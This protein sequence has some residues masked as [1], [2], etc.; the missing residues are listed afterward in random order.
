MN[1]G[2]LVRLAAAN[3]A[4]CTAER[5]LGWSLASIWRWC[6]VL[7]PTRFSGIKM[8][9]VVLAAKRSAYP[10]TMVLIGQ[11]NT[12]RGI[13]AALSSGALADSSSRPTANQVRAR[14]KLTQFI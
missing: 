1:L 9:E 14:D 4:G 10:Q 8:T 11:T 13:S 6:A 2:G 5:H 7:W 12:S 3:V